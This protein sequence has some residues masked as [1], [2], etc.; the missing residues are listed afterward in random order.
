MSNANPIAP[1][2]KQD[3]GGRFDSIEGARGV[4]ALMVFVSHLNLPILA[5]LESRVDLGKAGVVL[6]FFVSGFL[7]LPGFASQIKIREFIIKRFFRLYPVYWLSIGLAILLA[8]ESFSTVRVLANLTMFQEFMGFKNL[9]TVYW[10]LTIEMGFYVSL[11]VVGLIHRDFL[12]SK[13][14]ISFHLTGLA[15][16]AVAFARYQS[17]MKLPLALF[18]ALFVMVFGAILRGHLHKPLPRKTLA[19]F[20]AWFALYVGAS[21]MLG[22]SFATRFDENPQRYICSYAAGTLFFYAVLFHGSFLCRRPLL[23]L[24]QISYGFYVFHSPILEWFRQSYQSQAVVIF[25]SLSTA[26]LLSWVVYHLVE[27]PAIGWGRYLLGRLRQSKNASQRARNE[28]DEVV[29]TNES[30]IAP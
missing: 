18:L 13:L 14:R 26:L 2:A 10:T 25:G 24:G 22:Y 3:S 17:Q 29:A 15:A 7:V 21:C 19:T 20:Y 9:I 1:V 6:F 27:M 28:V 5:A 12:T 16:V 8:F 30:S 11:I 23:I 4:A